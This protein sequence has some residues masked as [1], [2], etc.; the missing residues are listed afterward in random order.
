MKTLL[1]IFSIFII[2]YSFGQKTISEY[3]I[4]AAKGDSLMKLNLYKDAAICYSAAFKTKGWKALAKDRYK[5]SIAWTLA[6]VPD[7]AF[8]NLDH[9]IRYQYY[10]D[11]D[12]IIQEQ[13]FKTLHSD[14]RWNPLLIKVKQNILPKGCFRAGSKPYSYEMF[15]DYNA[16]KEKNDVFSIKS[17]DEEIEGFGT[18]MQKSLPKEFL[19]R[20]I[21]MTGL[22]R[23]EN[24][25]GWAGFWVRVDH[26]DKQTLKAFDNMYD[27]PIKG[28][29]D[30]AFY[31]IVV[32]VPAKA[33]NVAFGA[34]LDGTGQIWFDKIEFEIVDKSVP[35]TGKYKDE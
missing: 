4:L 34:L 9:L 1:I 7:S 24:V 31:E 15:V 16:G 25:K 19:G 23:S 8:Y 28:T 30:W 18:L 17:I 13:G 35:T 3:R 20:K 29:T 5:A 32:Y 11:Y 33:T 14:K 6:G 27:R 22:M 26:P 21:R 10:S 2:Q 12:T